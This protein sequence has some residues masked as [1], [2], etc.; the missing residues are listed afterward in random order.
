MELLI[1]IETTDKNEM[2]EA[3]D[4]LN[5]KIAQINAKNPELKVETARESKAETPRSPEKEKPKAKATPA[6]KKAPAKAETP[7][8]TIGDLKNSA[9]D[10][11]L[12]TDRN[13]VRET[14]AEFGGKLADVS[15]ADYGKLYLKLQKLGA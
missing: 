4:L 14:I 12:R 9:K 3:I 8:I 1:K 13:K 5:Y 7:S 2:L 10:A 11:T 6:K 15:E